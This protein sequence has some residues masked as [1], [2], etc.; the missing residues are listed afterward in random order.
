MLFP[1]RHGVGGTNASQGSIGRNKGWASR[2]KIPGILDFIE[3]RDWTGAI[4][5]LTF[6]MRVEGAEANHSAMTENLFWMAYCYYHLG[7]FREA[8]EQLDKHLNHDP[9]PEQSAWLWKGLCEYG[10]G[11]YKEAE[12]CAFRGSQ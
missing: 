5:R 12:D 9:E 8:I 1:K 7:A 3:A 2:K 10:N 6:D 4:G 11:N